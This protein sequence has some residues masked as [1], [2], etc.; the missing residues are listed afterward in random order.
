MNSWEPFGRHADLLADWTYPYFVEDLLTHDGSA[1]PKILNYSKII[2]GV[3]GCT[4]RLHLDAQ[5]THAWLAQITGAKQVVLFAP[6][7]REK[8]RLHAWEETRSDALRRALDL[9]DPPDPLAY[10]RVYDATPWVATLAPGE[11]LLV[12]RG[13]WHYER[14]LD[15]SVT[16]MRN[17]ANSANSERFKVA[18]QRLNDYSAK[19]SPSHL[20]DPSSACV[21]CGDR[22][23]KPC[24]R[25]RAVSYCGRDCQR[26]AWPAHKGLCSLLADLDLGLAQPTDRRLTGANALFAAADGKTHVKHVVRDGHPDGA[27][28]N[29]ESMVRVHYVSYLA[30][31]QR[32]DS[33][34]DKEAPYDFH[35]TRSRVAQGWRD[36]ML[37][38]RVGEKARIA[39]PPHAAYAD[40]GV[41]GKV[42]PNSALVF[43]VELLEV[44]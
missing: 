39:I 20:V 16:L 33:S 40:R 19:H 13:W 43:D 32:I 8:L 35:L 44:W 15:V 21:S 28:P 3:P 41:R 4:T 37:T 31:G 6:S 42:P 22:P 5:E 36:A 34:V 24:S 11:V 29:N 9:A 25:C 17:F 23:A 1:N 12:P 10:P 14:C 27:S 2:V 7:D 38:M 30:D 26:K 18:V